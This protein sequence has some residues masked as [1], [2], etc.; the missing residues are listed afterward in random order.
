MT[1]MEQ[2]KAKAIDYRA[3]EAEQEPIVA[4]LG[5]DFQKSP[6]PELQSKLSR[7]TE[8][9]RHY[10]NATLGNPK[11]RANSA[12]E[13]VRRVTLNKAIVQI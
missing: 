9:L 11:V 5:E 4:K 10:S 13:T 1:E 12:A 2:E 6:S 7:E 3:K 8:I